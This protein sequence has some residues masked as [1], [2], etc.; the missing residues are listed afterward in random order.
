MV[1][2]SGHKDGKAGSRARQATSN[3]SRLRNPGEAFGT[4]TGLGVRRRESGGLAGSVTE[5]ELRQIYAAS[6][7]ALVTRTPGWPEEIGTVFDAAR[8]GVPLIVSDHD[9]DLSHRLT[10]EPW[11]GSFAPVIPRTSPGHSRASPK[12]PPPRPDRGAA[13]RLGLTS[14]T[15]TIAA[16][17]RIAVTLP[18]RR[19][20]RLLGTT[21]AR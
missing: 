19:R 21:S 11:V 18:K 13:E 16:F 10:G 20:I 2:V 7:G 8:Y 6:D 15:E 5:S 12:G 9:Q 1:A 4:R 14:V 17:C 3:A